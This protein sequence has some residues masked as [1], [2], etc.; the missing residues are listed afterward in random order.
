MKNGE[1]ESGAWAA[2]SGR[3]R[4]V[5]VDPVGS[6][7]TF[8]GAPGPRGMLLNLVE[9]SWTPRG[10]LGPFGMFLDPLGCS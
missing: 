10:S 8:W 1:T 6:S 7:W 2:R 9:C 5:L 4:G 3:T